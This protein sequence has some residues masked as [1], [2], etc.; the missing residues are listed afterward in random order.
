MTP[1]RY[2]RLLACGRRTDERG[3]TTLEL[4]ILGPGLLLFI[5]LVV[6][7]GRVELAG[8][9]VQQAADEAARSASIQRTKASA[10][11]V[12][13]DEARNTLTQQGLDC[14]TVSVSVNTK[15]FTAGPGQAGRVY[16]TVSCQ[17]NV[18]DLLLPGVPGTKTV[19]GRGISP[20]DTFR[21]RDR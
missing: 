17:V 7:A 2:R 19:T 12:A 8:Q 5:A 1:L 9:A 18:S 21:E 6:Y 14:A 11:G 3:S 15:D 4:C 10:D 20:I 16:T 13:A